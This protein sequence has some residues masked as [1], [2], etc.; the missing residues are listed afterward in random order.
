MYKDKFVLSILHKDQPLRETAGGG[1]LKVTIPFNSE[2]VIRLKNKN[3][4]DCTARVSIDGALIGHYDVI[5]R[6]GG[7]VDL[8]RFITDSL[9]KGK[10][11][12]FVRLS[13]PGVN[14]P[15]S[16]DNGIV[17]VEF[18]LAKRRH[19]ETWHPWRYPNT[20]IWYYSNSET[21]FNDQL[22][23]STFTSRSGDSTSDGEV[24][25]K[26]LIGNAS[27]GASVNYCHTEPG[28]T[29]EGNNSYQSFRMDDLDV[30]NYPTAILELQLVGIGKSEASVSR[31][32][33]RFC[34]NCGKEV[35]KKDR[36]CGGCG[37]RV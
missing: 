18:R 21:I 33:K 32:D 3:D 13:D 2:Y 8:E 16:S 7:T 19:I 28:A 14:D 17:K 4:L 22:G 1:R 9:D 27:I 29:V 31:S 36:Y 24:K 34:T 26:G 23:N 6:A 35:N 12:K 30:E 37:R 25:C 20:S 10:R 11:F 15:T 5:V